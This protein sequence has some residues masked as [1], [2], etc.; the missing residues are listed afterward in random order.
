LNHLTRE[1]LIGFRDGESDDPAVPEHLA[2]CAECQ[3]ALDD[4]RWSLSLQRLARA[5]PEHPSKEQLLAFW[6]NA[7]SAG[8]AKRVQRHLRSCGRCL[9]LYR[10][11]RGSDPELAY[12][13]PSPRLLR[14]VRRQFSP[15][16]LRHLGELWLRRIGRALTL[17]HVARDL[18]AEADGA[19][20]GPCLDEAAFRGVVARQEPPHPASARAR[21]ARL[22]KGRFETPGRAAAGRRGDETASSNLVTVD[23]ERLQLR[24]QVLRPDQD[25]PLLLS[26][27]WADTGK[28]ADD[29]G[30]RLSPQRGSSV[31]T[32]TDG[33][34][35]ARLPFPEGTS[36]LEILGRAPCVLILRR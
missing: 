7:L 20:L 4:S 26:A 2:T 34:G 19:P 14:R 11:L 28:P 24:L 16:P 25:N 3:R 8:S 29:L 31:E 33:R 30:M 36:A 18:L 1:Q 17:G 13:S 5:D 35:V 32:R 23:A 10:R 22:T 27:R 6:D 9:A 15:A 12:G 21:M